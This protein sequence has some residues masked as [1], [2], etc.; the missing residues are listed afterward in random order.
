MSPIAL[1]Q[2]HN[3]GHIKDANIG[4]SGSW[5]GVQMES[6]CLISMGQSCLCCA[7]VR[8]FTLI[9]LFSVVGGLPRRCLALRWWDIL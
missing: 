6:P 7:I 5:L 2:G 1:L 3:I 9:P 4:A 8:L